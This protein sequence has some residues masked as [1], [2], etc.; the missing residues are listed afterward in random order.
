MKATNFIKDASK[1]EPNLRIHANYLN[2]K[3]GMTVN[4]PANK[5]LPNID[6]VGVRNDET[7]IP[8]EAKTDSYKTGNIVLEAYSVFYLLP[9]EEASLISKYPSSVGSIKIPYDE[10][11]QDYLGIINKIVSPDF[12]TAKPGLLLS[13]IAKNHLLSYIYDRE[14]RVLMLKTT[15]LQSY[16]LSNIKTI[17]PTIIITK[18]AREDKSW[19]TV[20]LLFSRELLLSEPSVLFDGG[21]KPLF[22]NL[23]WS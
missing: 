22:D 21:I 12:T 4:R 8:I 14:S 6:L 3:L 17:K 19:F 11:N 20:S 1:S 10:S 2:T 15:E 13:T 18:S 7:E 16:I 5:N 9:E 23:K